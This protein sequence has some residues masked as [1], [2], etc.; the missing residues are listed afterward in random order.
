MTFYHDHETLEEFVRALAQATTYRSHPLGFED[1][2]S[3]Y[4]KTEAEEWVKEL[5]AR[6]APTHSVSAKRR[7]SEAMYS[8]IETDGVVEIHAT[9]VTGN[10][11]S[12]CGLDGNDPAVGQMVV[13]LPNK[14]VITCKSCLAIIKH[15]KGYRI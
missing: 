11:A 1:S 10:Y 7:T 8:A 13:V 14:P 12:L 3:D 6:L 9:D 4:W 5:D 15:A 2:L